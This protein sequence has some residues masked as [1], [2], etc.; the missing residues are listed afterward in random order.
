VY[1]GESTT[2]IDEKGRITVPVRIR[3]T[4]NVE[5]HAIWY[6]T[7][8]FDRCVFLFH[9]DEWMRIRKAAKK[10]GSINARA[11]DFRRLLFGG[12][13]E[14]RPDQQGRM[15]VAP[16]LREHANID[17]EAVLVGV[18]DHLELWNKDAWN[19]FLTNNEEE[20][21]GMAGA[22]FGGEESDDA[23]AETARGE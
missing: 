3:E 16:H 9:R 20:F 18:D 4:M 13:A 19:A 7:R 1:F 14:V 8:G 23:A 21:K 17:K 22:I 12:V 10:S 6:M 2:R 15:A 11:L 5:G